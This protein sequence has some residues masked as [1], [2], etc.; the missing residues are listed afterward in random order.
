[1][2]KSSEGEQPG[3]LDHILVNKVLDELRD[4]T[5]V[6]REIK[7]VTIAQLGPYAA[8]KKFSPCPGCG[9]P[10]GVREMRR[11]LKAGCPAAP[12]ATLPEVPDVVRNPVHPA[13]SS[14]TA[15]ILPDVPERTS[16][17]GI[18]GLR[19]GPCRKTPDL[20]PRYPGRHN[21]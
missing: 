3:P 20:H 12:V 13:R 8:E 2:T 10:L 6:L 17:P 21:G 7:A 9:Q 16:R 15:A 19:S 5:K 11:H 14:R 18:S 4:A 1:M